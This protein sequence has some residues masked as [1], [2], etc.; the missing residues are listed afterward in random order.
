MTSSRLSGSGGVYLPALSRT[1][2]S[3]LGGERAR[4]SADFVGPVLVDADERDGGLRYL[5]HGGSEYVDGSRACAARGGADARGGEAAE[6]A[7][8]GERVW[9]A[10]EGNR[11]RGGR[12]DD[13]VC[14]SALEGSA[15]RRT[16]GVE[17]VVV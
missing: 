12:H 1:V 7:G 3:S 13:E 2:A 8:E 17:P 14:A 5:L 6:Q 16:G 9:G 11:R 15:K 4:Q 10:I